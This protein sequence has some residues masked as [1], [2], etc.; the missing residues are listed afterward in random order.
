M[1]IAQ[2]LFT[3]Q[4]FILYTV[5]MTYIAD[6]TPSI[7][8]RIAD[9]RKFRKIGTAADLA[10]RIPNPKVTASV[11]QN[12]ESGRK[13][14]LSVSQLLDI[15]MGLG[16]SP[17]VLLVP[18]GSPFQEVDL[19]GVGDDVSSLTVR[20]FDEWLTIPAV[21]KAV[22]TPEQVSMRI[23]VTYI[24]KLINAVEDWKIAS[25]S[26]D[27][28]A[29]PTEF[30]NTDPEGNP[31]TDTYDPAEVAWMHLDAAVHDVKAKCAYLRQYNVDL[32]WVP[33]VD[34]SRAEHRG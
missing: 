1:T 2:V 30:E 32:S 17:L 27:F 19:P 25:A 24:R 5:K 18:V 3:R 12:I 20:E 28:D 10:A 34:A 31:Y 8:K 21:T 26:P 4:G 15:A 6:S 23:L 11:I 14:D 29:V 9:Y 33:D 22:E 16:V 13:A 7:G